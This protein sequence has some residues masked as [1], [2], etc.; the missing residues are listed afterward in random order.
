MF[1]SRVPHKMQNLGLQFYS[2]VHKLIVRTK[3]KLALPPITLQFKD[4][5]KTKY[6]DQLICLRNEMA[7][8]LM[9]AQSKQL[10]DC[11]NC[12]KGP[13]RKGRHNYHQDCENIVNEQIYEELKASL[14]Y[15]AMASYFGRTDVAFPGCHGYFLNMHLEEHEHAMVFFNYQLMRGADVKLKTIEA[16]D[17]HEFP[18]MTGV[19]EKALDME[20]HVKDVST[21][22]IY[23]L[24]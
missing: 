24:I 4:E 19:F 17:C 18:N 8:S 14:M 2:F 20:I 16:P 12:K 1:S 15:L 3:T 13:I 6:F 9:I 23:S 10:S 11:S 7:N 21:V 5:P 22:I